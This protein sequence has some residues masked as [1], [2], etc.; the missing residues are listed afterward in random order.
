MAN[1]TNESLEQLVGLAAQFKEAAEARVN[2]DPKLRAKA[3]AS[4]KPGEMENL[5]ELAGELAAGA[6]GA[7]F[8][9]VDEE[10]LKLNLKVADITAD[11]AQRVMEKDELAEYLP[12]GLQSANAAEQLKS[13]G[14]DNL[15]A[16]VEH[17]L[18]L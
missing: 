13:N 7:L 18:S 1:E 4:L 15:A 2:G 10:F 17:K 3:I 16:L 8:G 11:L 6:L 9:E 12:E 14:A 5:Q